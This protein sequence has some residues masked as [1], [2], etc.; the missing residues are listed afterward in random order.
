MSVKEKSRRK[1]KGK[2]A[3]YANKPI[4]FNCLS[5][6][7]EKYRDERGSKKNQKATFF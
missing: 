6:L 5:C 3:K 7:L 2:K 4:S 1:K